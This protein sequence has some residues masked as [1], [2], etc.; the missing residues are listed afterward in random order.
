[1]F[2]DLRSLMHSGQVTHRQVR[3][4]IAIYHSPRTGSVVAPKFNRAA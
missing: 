2:G 4:C 1:M 3:E